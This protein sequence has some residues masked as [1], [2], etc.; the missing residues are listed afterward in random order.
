MGSVQYII[1]IAATSYAHHAL[2][3][4]TLARR[5]EVRHREKELSLFLLSYTTSP[6]GTTPRP[7]VA[8]PLMPRLPEGK[9]EKRER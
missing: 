1:I 4:A 5:E 3:K 7:P 6:A 2:S 8:G 9:G